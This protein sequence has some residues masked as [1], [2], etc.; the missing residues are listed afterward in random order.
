M[1][2]RRFMMILA[3]TMAL[4]IGLTSGVFAE[5][6]EV[7][8][9]CYFDGDEIV[10]DFD[11]DIV[12]KTVSGL[13]PG[14]DVTFKVKFENRYPGTTHWYMRNEALITLEESY[15][16]TQ[17]GGYTY[18]LTH[19]APDGS[20]NVLFDNSEVGGEAKPANMEGL[21]QAT[22]ALDEWFFI[23]DLKKGQSG[24][25]EL[26]VKFDGDSEVND[27]MDTAGK[28]LVAYAVELD[29]TKPEKIRKRVDTGDTNNL[30]NYVALMLAAMLLL[31]LTI[32]SYRKD[33]REMR[34]EAA[35]DAS[36]DEMTDEAPAKKGLFRK[37]RE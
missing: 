16:R 8:G 30:L 21:H 1:M 29:S 2:K 35:G 37:E 18:I 36:Y 31:I 17:N 32:L 27:Y 11:S 22:N 28:L 34:A 12:V 6:E 24:Y 20:R 10:C 25:T 3:L 26:Y 19:V 23:Q 14:D 33:R 13:E 9:Y 15:D 5:S 7:T 4:V